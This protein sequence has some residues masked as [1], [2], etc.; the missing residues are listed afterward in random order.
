MNFDRLWFRKNNNNFNLKSNRGPLRTQGE[1]YQWGLSG[2]QYDPKF[3][4]AYDHPWTI[5]FQN[6]YGLHGLSPIVWEKI[7][8]I[9]TDI[10]TYN[11]RQIY[12]ERGKDLIVSFNCIHTFELWG[13]LSRTPLPS[14]RARRPHNKGNPGSLKIH[15]AGME[16][17]WP[18]RMGRL[19]LRGTPLP[20]DGKIP[21]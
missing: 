20:S 16:P 3:F 2:S 11:K 21:K 17:V 13:L 9:H 14:G 15:P 6:I 1:N 12:R 10:H 19:F 5:S 4:I 7:E 18:T 8:D